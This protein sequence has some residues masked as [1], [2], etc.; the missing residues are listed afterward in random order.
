MAQPRPDRPT[1]VTSCKMIM[2]IRMQMMIMK[3]ITIGIR[4]MMTN[5][6]TGL[7]S[8]KLSDM[9]NGCHRDKNTYKWSLNNQIN[10]QASGCQFGWEARWM[11][12]RLKLYGLPRGANPTVTLDSS[13]LSPTP[14]TTTT[15]TPPNKHKH[16]YHSQAQA[17]PLPPR[18]T[19]TSTTGC[20]GNH[21]CGNDNGVDAEKG[22]PHNFLSLSIRSLPTDIS[23]N[24]MWEM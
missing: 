20:V 6:I 9:L 1:L 10:K 17:L 22:N 19:S 4:M 7:Q 21:L 13:S 5:S 3:M 15:T 14:T 12:N 24:F 11:T 8:H 2:M 18:P 23:H 16:H